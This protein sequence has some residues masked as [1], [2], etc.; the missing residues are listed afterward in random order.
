M[1]RAPLLSD[2]LLPSRWDGLRLYQ[3]MSAHPG[4]WFTSGCL[5]S[6]LPRW[7]YAH[8]G[9][10]LAPFVA[11]GWVELDI[12]DPYSFSRFR[13]PTPTQELERLERNL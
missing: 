8:A 3:I 11:R 7:E 5:E 9:R 2:R 6:F 10:A 4:R 12:E 1:R 13:V